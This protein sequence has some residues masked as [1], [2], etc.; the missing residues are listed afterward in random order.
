VAKISDEIS[1]EMAECDRNFAVICGV[2]NMSGQCFDKKTTNSIVGLLGTVDNGVFEM[3]KKI[4]GFVEFSR[5]LGVICTEAN[6]VVFT[7]FARSERNAQLEASNRELEAMAELCGATVE[8]SESYGGWSFDGYTSLLKAYTDA[9]RK[10][11]G[12]DAK[13]CSIHA[14]LE[15][16]IIKA[17]IPDMD[18]IAVGPDA[19]GI[20]SPDEALNL[21]TVTSIF[22]IIKD[23]L[24][25]PLN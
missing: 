23:V 4:P 1:S 9:Y 16:G 7:F 8:Y 25:K 18:I 15:C 21:D 17:A 20:H 6:N 13:V 19:Y 10:I 11:M 2:E 3:S 12:N 5:N 24:S 22:E 14:G